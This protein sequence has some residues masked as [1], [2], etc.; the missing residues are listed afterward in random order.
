[1]MERFW[2]QEAKL[3]I[4]DAVITDHGSSV[5]RES[6]EDFS[7]CAWRT[8]DPEVCQVHP[9]L[10]ILVTHR[11]MTLV[12]TSFFMRKVQSLQLQSK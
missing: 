4:T 8:A 10:C 11:T 3:S 2:L 6:V 5:N 9:E 12:P 1:M 7:V